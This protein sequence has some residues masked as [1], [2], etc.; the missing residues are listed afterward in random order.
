MLQNLLRYLCVFLLTLICGS[1]VNAMLFQAPAAGSEDFQKYAVEKNQQTYTQWV[2][3]N[4]AESAAE[5][6]A[7]VLEFSQR[8]LQEKSVKQLMT[9]WDR[10]RKSIELNRMDRELLTLLAEK[11]HQE[12]ELCRYPS[13][14][15]ELAKLL[16]EPEAVSKCARFTVPLP[17][18]VSAQI[19]ENDLLVIDGTAFTKSQLPARM[20]KG[21]YQW[22]IISDRFE[23]RLFTGTAEEFSEQ[24]FLKQSWVSGHCQDYKMQTGD[25]S[26][27]LQAQVYFSESCVNPGI[28][29]EKTF[30]DWASDHKAFLW[31]AAIL[32]TGLAAAQL[33]DK[34]LVITKP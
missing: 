16:E 24:S 28:P 5:A 1:R 10:L 18:A 19:D 13:M 27:L 33:K 2:L 20:V 7:Q 3:R 12:Q 4:S 15:P 30:T 14:E 32:A 23:D 22:K 29:R 11:L 9:D 6:H 21:S 34:T 8:A 26:L 17:K 25:F 31:G